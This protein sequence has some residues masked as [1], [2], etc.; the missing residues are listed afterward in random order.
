MPD[1]FTRL[2]IADVTNQPV[3]TTNIAMAGLIINSG[4]WFD[5]VGYNLT[6][7]DAGTFSNDGTLRLNN[8]Q[9]ITGFTNDTDSGA[10][11]V[12]PSGNT[13]GLQT[14]NSYFDLILNDSLVGYWQL[15]ETTSGS[16]DS[17]I[18]RSGYD[19]HGTPSGSSGGNNKPQPATAVPEVNFI[20]S[21][22]LDFDGD[23]DVVTVLDADRFDLGSTFT[24]TAWTYV[25]THDAGYSFLI[26]RDSVGDSSYDL[27]FKGGRPYAAIN[28]GVW[29]EYVADDVLA[30]G[31]W[32]HIAATRRS[33]NTLQIYVDGTEVKEFTS[34]KTPRN[35][36]VNVTIGKRTS[37]SYEHDG[38]IDDVR[39]YNTDLSD[40]AIAR[41]GAGE[42]PQY[43][44]T[45]TTLSADLTVAGDLILN[46]GTLDTSS[47][48]NYGVTVAGNFENN[49]GIFTPQSG[50]VTLN[51][52][53]QS[54]TSTN[55]F[56]D[57]I[58]AVTA[59]DTLTFAQ[60]STTT[61]TNS[62]SLQ[63]QSG[64]LLTLASAVGGTQ[65]S[66][67]PQGN[68]SFSYLSVADSNNTN[69][70]AIGYSSSTTY[71][72]N[73]TNWT[74]TGPAESQESNSSESSSDSSEN[75]AGS[76][77][78]S[79]VAPDGSP[80]LF[81]IDTTADTAIIYFTPL[82]ST[83]Q[84][85][86][87]FSSQTSAEEHGTQVQLGS[88]GVQRYTVN[89]LS[90]N[91]TY[92]FKVRGQY[93]C[94][95]GNWS[96]IRVGQTKGNQVQALVVQDVER[97]EP[98]TDTEEIV[99]QTE[100]TKKEKEYELTVTV[101][102]QKEPVVGAEVALASGEILGTTNELGEVTFSKVKQGKYALKVVQ[103]AY[104]AEQEIE[105]R[106]DSDKFDILVNLDM[107]EQTRQ[108]YLYAAVILAVLN[109]FLVGFLFL[110]KKK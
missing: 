9:T 31:E 95:P 87:S 110:R 25:D 105:V 89:L 64:N 44:T 56:Y 107:G 58:K 41:L 74:T 73:L 36:G 42:T 19:G 70:T 33:D 43:A 91:T 21:R 86:V 81:Q 34:V 62:T 22:S 18:D 97:G 3:A 27:G 23:D 51:G 37:S 53:S 48:N 4:A 63:G 102:N 96:E 6:M 40:A 75:T 39:I 98:I 8:S 82:L 14:G 47:G 10:V 104:A 13:T 88:D 26:S 99:L 72:S 17:V 1:P 30:T 108:K 28:D 80:D 93:G 46:S 38:R 65:F 59:T 109:L 55:T 35:A 67:N 7:N 5:L 106:G 79:D 84:Y 16:T 76:T 54:I 78:C 92:Y 83:D 2:T 66:I 85:Y 49:G 45:T 77:G 71:G 57:L 69:A 50:A 61:I 32:H 60:R 29:G 94:K 20:D 100:P 90:P 101:R 68:R 52:S 12:Y 103:Q 11:M 24:L 15:D